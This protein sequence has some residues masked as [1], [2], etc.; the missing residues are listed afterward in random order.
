MSSP[1]RRDA[2]AIRNRWGGDVSE[3]SSR[4]VTS[5]CAFFQLRFQHICR[6]LLLT[7]TSLV[8]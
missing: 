1:N 5:L 8:E 6:P 2:V 3:V 7:S 4:L